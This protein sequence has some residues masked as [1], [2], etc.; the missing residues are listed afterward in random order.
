MPTAKSD[1][2]DAYLAAVPETQRAALAKLRELIRR[3]Y[4]NATEH[5]R[6]RQPR[7]KLDGHP[8]GGF[9]AAKHHGALY[10]WSPTAVA[11][12]GDMFDGYETAASTVRFAPDQ[13]LPERIVTALFDLRARE[14][15]DRWGPRA[16][17]KQDASTG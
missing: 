4:P 14:I 3:L 9:Y 10:V 11:T 15:R 5:I 7:F 12:L 6:Y 8:L 16:A 13:P 17:R 2:I 1:S